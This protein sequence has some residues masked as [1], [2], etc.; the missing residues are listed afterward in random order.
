MKSE[1]RAEMV[2]ACAALNTRRVFG[3]PQPLPAI[4]SKQPAVS[5]P[6]FVDYE[7]TAGEDVYSALSLKS[8]VS[9]LVYGSW[10][11]SSTGPRA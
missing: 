11:P 4:R 1:T 8:Y 2:L 6:V 3:G 7:H 10:L 5:L 9:Q